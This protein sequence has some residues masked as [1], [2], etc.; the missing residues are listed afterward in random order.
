MVKKAEVESEWLKS[1]VFKKN[2]LKSSNLIYLWN[3]D[4]L[5]LWY[6]DLKLQRLKYQTFAKI[7]KD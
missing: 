7:S 4:D 5:N 3:S 6:L 1:N 2:G